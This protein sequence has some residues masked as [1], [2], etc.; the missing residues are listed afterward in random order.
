MEW[1]RN[2]CGVGEAGNPQSRR[3]QTRRD[4]RRYCMRDTLRIYVL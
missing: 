4:A 2:V 1:R 3:R